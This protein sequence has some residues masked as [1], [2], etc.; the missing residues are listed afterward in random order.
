MDERDFE[1]LTDLAKTQNIT[2][3]AQ[4]LFTTQSAITKRIQK[5][6]SDLG[7]Q[8][9][10]RSKTGLLPLPALER[11]LPYLESVRDAT[12][13]I[14]NLAGSYNGEIC[15]ALR[16]GVSVNYAR[17]RLP[18]VLTDYMSRYPKVDIHAKAN[19]S[20]DVYRALTDG[21]V[22]VAIIRGEYAWNGGDI[23]LSEEPHCLVTNRSHENTPLNKLTYIARDT[24]AGYMAELARW[25]S[26]NGLRPTRSNLIMNDVPTIVTMVEKGMGWS[27]LPSICLSGFKGVI[28]PVIL[29]DGS[30][31]VRKTHIL[32]RPDYLALPQARAFIETAKQH[33]I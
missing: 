13:T 25:M 29:K 20:P 11:I 5:L 32:Y 4:R 7:A 10:S 8:L 27:V 21:E 3:T 15:G 23:L 22:S 1:V 24:D 28:K 6:E 17:Y 16:I 9:F 12:E 2:K 33:E 30:S 18:D 14:R 19:R 26:E 31:F